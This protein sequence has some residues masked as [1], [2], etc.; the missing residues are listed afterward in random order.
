MIGVACWGA[1][2]TGEKSGLFTL[3]VQ[4]LLYWG[5][6]ELPTGLLQLVMS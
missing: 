4:V 5:T 3:F 1:V 6:K 2:F